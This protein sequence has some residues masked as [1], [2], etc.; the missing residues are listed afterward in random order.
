MRHA[1][2]MQVDIG[3]DGFFA[4]IGADPHAAKVNIALANDQ[5][6][7]HDGDDFVVGADRRRSRTARPSWPGAVPNAP[8]GGRHPAL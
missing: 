1:L 3:A 8:L 5:A 2:F 7:I 6:L 4:K